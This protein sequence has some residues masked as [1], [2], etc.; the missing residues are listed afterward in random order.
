MTYVIRPVRPGVTPHSYLRAAW[1]GRGREIAGVM[2]HATRS[3]TKGTKDGPGTEN[4][5]GHPSNTQAVSS[6]WDSLFWDDGT[7]VQLGDRDNSFPTWCAG[8]GDAGTWNA[9]LYYLQYELAQGTVDSPFAEATIDSLAQQVARDAKTYDFPIVR[10]PFLTQV[11][12]VPRGITA[13]DACANGRKLGKSDPGY[14]F[15]WDAFIERANHYLNGGED[16]LS[17]EDR[18]R[19][20]RLER[21]L[22]GNGITVRVTADNIDIVRKGHPDA[23]VG[24]DRVLIGGH[25]VEYLDVMQISVPEGTHNLNKALTEHIANHA[26]GIG[27]VP[28][29]THEPGKVRR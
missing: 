18:A 5:L 15:P 23:K 14:L 22:G 9:G 11:G 17:A 21:L 27:G 10:L 12:P 7:Q 6:S 20:D 19:L 29:H 3:G 25:A 13:H 4:W 16:E 2:I 8:Y 24:E 1:A 28:E 26:S